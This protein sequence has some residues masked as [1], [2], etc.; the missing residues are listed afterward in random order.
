M[1]IPEC[2]LEYKGYEEA[3]QDYNGSLAQLDFSKAEYEEL[4]NLFSGLTTGA[5]EDEINKVLTM[6]LDFRNDYNEP[7]PTK[8][9]PDLC[10]Y[11]EELEQIT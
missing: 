9:D 10:P 2:L 7:P 4:M 8:A 5:P 11:F 3:S 6:P 1:A